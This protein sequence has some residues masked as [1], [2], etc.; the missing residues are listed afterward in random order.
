MLA[1]TV[2]TIVESI[3]DYYATARACCVPP[4]PRHAVN[5]G[6][7]M[8]GFGSVICGLLGAAHATTSYSSTVGFVP[9]TG[10]SCKCK[11][12]LSKVN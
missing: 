10:V 9:L 1:A 3:G 5:R 8:E 12:Y 7:A 2:S 4:P 11:C 6:I